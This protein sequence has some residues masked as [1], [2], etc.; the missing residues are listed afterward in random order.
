M[1][2]LLV[3]RLL[4][5]LSQD[6]QVSGLTEFPEARWR[7]AILFYLFGIWSNKDKVVYRPKIAFGDITLRLDLRDGEYYAHGHAE[8]P[9]Y[10]P[11]VKLEQGLIETT[12]L[13]AEVE[14]AL[15]RFVKDNRIKLL[16]LQLPASNHGQ[17][18]LW[19]KA[20]RSEYGYAGV[21]L[22]YTWT[23]EGPVWTREEYEGH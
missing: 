10:P 12:G 7:E 1:A 9:E 16:R 4:G 20:K 14:V 17:L 21:N 3:K 23:T 2:T 15:I 11:A 13:K 8:S 18:V 5:V 22:P 6:L 19:K